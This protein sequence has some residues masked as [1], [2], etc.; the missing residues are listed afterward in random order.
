MSDNIDSYLKYHYLSPVPGEIVSVSV[1]KGLTSVGTS[2]GWL[3]LLDISTGDIIHGLQVHTG[4]IC[5]VSLNYDGTIVASC[6]S[7]DKYVCLTNLKN[8]SNPDIIDFTEPITVVAIDSCASSS[9]SISSSPPSSSNGTCELLVGTK[10]GSVIMY[11]HQPNKWTSYGRKKELKVFNGAR[12][13]VRCISRRKSLVAWA[14]W[15]QIRVVNLK[16]S[17]P[18]FY[19]TSSHALQDF[20]NSYLSMLWKDDSNIYICWSNNFKHIQIESEDNNNNN[21]N[22]S[23]GSR[24]GESKDHSLK[25]IV[26]GD[27][28]FSKNDLTISSPSSSAYDSKAS[29]GKRAKTKADWFVSENILGLASLGQ[30]VTNG[31]G[32]GLPVTVL[33]LEPSTSQTLS[34]T[35]SEENSENK[36]KDIACACAH[37]LI[38]NPKDGEVYDAEWIEGDYDGGSS[39]SISISSGVDKIQNRNHVL[40]SG[41]TYSNASADPSSNNNDN[42]NDNNESYNESFTY[43]VIAIHSRLIAISRRS[44]DDRISAM[45]TTGDYPRAARLALYNRNALTRFHFWE[46][47]RLSVIHL[48]NGGKTREAAFEVKALTIHSS[49]TV[50]WAYWIS[51]FNEYGCLSQLYDLIPIGHLHL[52]SSAYEFVLA[53][54]LDEAKMQYNEIIP[55]IN[56]KIIASNLSN[57]LRRWLDEDTNLFDYE[58]FLLQLNEILDENQKS[59]LLINKRNHNSDI[60][61]DDDNNTVST[62]TDYSA[63]INNNNN[64]YNSDNNTAYTTDNEII[65]GIKLRCIVL[66]EAKAL[67]LK[68]LNKIDESLNSYLDIADILKNINREGCIE[69][70]HWKRLSNNVLNLLKNDDMTLI[71]SI[72]SERLRDLVLLCPSVLEDILPNYIHMIKISSVVRQL[73]YDLKWQHRYLHAISVNHNNEYNQDKYQEFHVLQIPLYANYYSSSNCYFNFDEIPPLIEF[74][75]NKS[76]YISIDSDLILEE[77]KHHDPPLYLETAH[78]L[79][80]R[81]LYWSCIEVSLEC[82]VGGTPYSAVNY[83]AAIL[84]LHNGKEYLQDLMQRCIESDFNNKTS[85]IINNSKS[86][87]SKEKQNSRAATLLAFLSTHPLASNINVQQLVPKLV[88]SIP[89]LPFPVSGVRDTCELLLKRQEELVLQAAVKYKLK[90]NEAKRMVRAKNS[91]IR[92]ALRFNHANDNHN[93][94]N[95]E[96]IN[97]KCVICLSGNNNNNNNDSNNNNDNNGRIGNNRLLLFPNGSL[98]HQQ[99]HTRELRQIQMKMNNAEI[100]EGD[101]NEEEEDDETY[102]TEELHLDD[103]KDKDQGP[104]ITTL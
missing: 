98:K 90:S 6:A 101:Y 14:D 69:R 32:G 27:D 44:V 78:L 74:C 25:R 81:K 39:S 66:L 36:D 94:H 103:D 58:S 100:V 83:A 92:N 96:S 64:N 31:G 87:K 104:I 46:L 80:A 9:S 15:N 51:I 82:N 65:I 89:K 12:S 63:T 19:L 55:D 93:N 33:I 50:A 52:D 60:I 23:G 10:S 77:C 21:N 72:I 24:N 75:L 97:W 37:V 102:H 17:V 16:G 41:D 29:N 40:V 18:L 95:N 49:D 13:P 71:I 53:C 99:C 79:A 28:N 67:I 70:L 5:S 48:L 56:T 59:I 20:E 22:S 84:L 62:V 38:T 42:V 73:R 76:S 91:G 1:C 85:D 35:S 34:K 8:K 11:Y 43:A 45:L 61:S 3:Y 86:N 2:T 88:R 4:S 26:D 7:N 47:M 30:P 54:F 57:C 68:S